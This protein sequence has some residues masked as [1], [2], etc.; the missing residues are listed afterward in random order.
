MIN[1]QMIYRKIE[2]FGIGHVHVAVFAFPAMECRYGN[3][4]FTADRVD[5]FIGFGLSKNTDHLFGN[6][7][8]LFHEPTPH[9]L[10]NSLALRG[11]NQGC[12]AKRAIETLDE[13]G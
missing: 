7:L 5:R 9:R 2:P 3:I 6:V 1:G 8:F 10:R 11:A 13:G 4:M 12:H